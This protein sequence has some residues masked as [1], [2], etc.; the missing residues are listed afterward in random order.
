MKRLLSRWQ[1]FKATQ[2]H[3]QWHGLIY[4]QDFL[5]AVQSTVTMCIS[6]SFCN[7]PPDGQISFITHLH[8]K[9]QLSKTPMELCE[10]E[11]YD[12]RLSYMLGFCLAPCF[13]HYS[14]LGSSQ[15]VVAIL[16]TLGHPSCPYIT[17]SKHQ[18]M[19]YEVVKKSDNVFGCFHK[20]YRCGEKD[21]TVW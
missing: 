1:S 18:I 9:S 19:G 17:P 3:P 14:R 7:I 2:D 15:I 5:L 21:G 16:F 20:K 6:H 13:C 12:D 11:D 10:Q 4:H 8:L